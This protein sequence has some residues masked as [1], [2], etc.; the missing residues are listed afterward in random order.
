MAVAPSQQRRGVGSLLL[1]WVCNRDPTS[2]CY[3]MASPAGV[4]LYRKFGFKEVGLVESVHGGSTSMFKTG[5]WQ[6]RGSLS[7]DALESTQAVVDK[8]DEQR[9]QECI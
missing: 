4:P 9:G 8:V 6:Q 5:C 3:V 2:D 7:D 1:D